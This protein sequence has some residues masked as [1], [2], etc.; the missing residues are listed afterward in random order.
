[1]RHWLGRLAMSFVIVGVAILFKIHQL[2]ERQLLTGTQQGLYIA[3]AVVCFA[4]GA[5]GMKERHRGE[6]RRF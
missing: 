3:A 1:M 4:L 6:E 5:A 2:R